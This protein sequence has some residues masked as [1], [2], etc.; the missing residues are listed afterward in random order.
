MGVGLSCKEYHIIY[1]A[2][3]SVEFGKSNLDET[4]R[5]YRVLKD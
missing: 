3:L 1:T 5:Q 4:P 2:E